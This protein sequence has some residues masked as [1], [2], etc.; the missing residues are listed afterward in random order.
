MKTYMFFLE[1]IVVTAMIIMIII[2]GRDRKRLNE[3]IA[4]LSDNKDNLAQ[5]LKDADL[6]LSELNKSSDYIVT[7]IDLKNVELW[8]SI[9]KY[10]NKL[11]ELKNE[12]ESILL[13]LDE[14]VEALREK[15]YSPQINA[16]Q[17]SVLMT[18]ENRKW[19]H[20]ISRAPIS[21][22]TQDKATH[23]NEKYAKVV[24]LADSGI[25]NTEIARRLNMCMSEIQLVLNISNLS[26]VPSISYK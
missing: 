12:S 11:A 16:P 13:K 4:N 9:K 21:R 6:M 17:K 24:E 5:L 18:I 14:S 3:L 20:D 10:D 8:N 15:V 23:Y 25:S 22:K 19:N 2:A 7:Q 1:F 26:G